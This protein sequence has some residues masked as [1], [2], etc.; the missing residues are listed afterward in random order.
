MSAAGL[1]LAPQRRRQRIGRAGDDD[2]VERRLLGPTEMAVTVPDL[3][4]GIALVLEA[5]PRRPGK[6]LDDFDCEDVRRQ[7]SEDRRLIAGAAADLQDLPGGWQLQ[8]LGH[9][10]DDVRLGDRLPVAD[11]KRR[12]VIGLVADRR[13]NERVPRDREHRV[14]HARVGD[15]IAPVARVGD[16]SLDHPPPLLDALVHGPG[17]R[18]SAPDRLGRYGAVV[19]AHQQNP[20][21]GKMR[22]VNH[23]S[24][25]LSFPFF[26]THQMISASTV[27]AA[28][29]LPRNSHSVR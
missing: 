8:M 16:L 27:N 21:Y 19:G 17:D 7:V 4:A 1:E 6:L 11:R 3:D 13:R 24:A 23:S 14:E 10:R 25:I 12:V 9:Q 20:E 26:T 2:G 29:M 18:S 15:G 5:L 22:R 28:L